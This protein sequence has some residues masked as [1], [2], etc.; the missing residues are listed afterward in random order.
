MNIG[1]AVALVLVVGCGEE[2]VPGADD[3]VGV[4][5][6]YDGI[7]DDDVADGILDDPQGLQNRHT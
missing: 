3:Q 4:I 5:E 1:W 7:G 6:D 2:E